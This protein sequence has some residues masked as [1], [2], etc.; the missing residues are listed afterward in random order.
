VKIVPKADPLR[1]VTSSTLT[2]FI[3]YLLAGVEQSS[4]LMT[5]LIGLLWQFLLM[6][7]DD[8]GPI[9]GVNE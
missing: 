6:D 1:S 8:Y 2:V 5:S 9:G 4:L 3:I 7:D